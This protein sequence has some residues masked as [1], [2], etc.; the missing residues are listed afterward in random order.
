MMDKDIV[1][2]T[3]ATM[4]EMKV[5]DSGIENKLVNNLIKVIIILLI[6]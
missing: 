4:N 3:W 5:V 6:V 2:H 1:E